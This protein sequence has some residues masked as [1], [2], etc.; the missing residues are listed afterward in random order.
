MRGRGCGC[1]KKI[2]FRFDWL[3]MNI[4]FCTYHS[5]KI[6]TF[7]NFLLLMLLLVTG[8]YSFCS[9]GLDK[10]IDTTLY[11]ILDV[12]YDGKPDSITLHIV[13]N[14]IDLPFTWTFDIVSLGT[15]IY[16]YYQNDSA[17]NE[18]FSDTNYISGCNNSYDCKRK[19]YY[20]DIMEYSVQTSDSI[21]V[22][23]F[24]EVLS[25]YSKNN[26]A[27]NYFVDSLQLS[28]DVSEQIL[29]NIRQRLNEQ[30]IRYISILSTPHQSG[31]VEVY[32][33][34]LKK[35]ISIYCD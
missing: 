19:H 16:H 18:Y 23:W 24:I 17:I 10:K 2:I 8:N 3:L 1:G 20:N 14:T 5:A 34:E 31:C 15:L 11:R 7:Y 21:E 29:K 13:G 35:F 33:P 32:V 28:M 22:D 26:I 30:R 27:R 12:T 25:D 9:D 4:I 6:L